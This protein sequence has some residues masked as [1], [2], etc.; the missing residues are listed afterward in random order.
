MRQGIANIASWDCNLNRRNRTQIKQLQLYWRGSDT[1]ET[2]MS[3]SSALYHL[4][5]HTF[6]TNYEL[7][8]TLR[9]HVLTQWL[10]ARTSQPARPRQSHGLKRFQAIRISTATSKDHIGGDSGRYSE[11][12]RCSCDCLV[13]VMFLCILGYRL[14]CVLHVGRLWR[15]DQDLLFSR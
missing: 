6:D 8:R 15:S 11:A 7:L 5:N 2:T 1:C 14:L 4:H 12:Y 9:W 13:R 3:P 10:Y